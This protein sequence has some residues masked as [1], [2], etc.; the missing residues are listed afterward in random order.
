MGQRFLSNDRREEHQLALDWLRETIEKEAI[1]LLIVA[2]DIFDISNPPSSARTMYY[3]FLAD[4]RATDCRHIVIVGGNHD[5]PSMLNA[6]KEILEM[7]NVHVVGAVTEN[8]EDEI[9]ELRNINGQ[10]EAVVAAVPFLRDRDLRYSVA[11]ETGL[12]RRVKVQEGII[13]H[14][15]KVGQAVEKYRDGEV[16]ILVTGHLYAKGAKASDK[17]DNIYVGNIEN[18][19]GNHFPKIFEYVALGH[20]HRAQIVGEQQHVRYSGSLI[21]LSFSEIQDSKI[22]QILTFD[23]DKKLTIDELKVPRF[24]ELVRFSGDLESVKGKLERF[25]EKRKGELKPWID[26]E[27]EMKEFIPNLNGELRAF[28]KDMWLEILKIRTPRPRQSL[29]KLTTETNLDELTTE[30]V[31]LKKCESLGEIS[32]KE[33]DGLL[34]TF[35]ELQVWMKEQEE[36]N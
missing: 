33:R 1:D 21:P 32:E 23:I 19:A 31:F 15:E 5:S 36:K 11:G 14:F 8:I 17:Q 34:L 12:E 26:I 4:L 22:V 18:I 25:D 2:G 24:R 30:E 16:P 27:V 13:A 6:P 3:R 10:L 29:E 35:R 9:I 7:L 20:I 28:A